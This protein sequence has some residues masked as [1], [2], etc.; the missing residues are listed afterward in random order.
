MESLEINLKEGEALFA[1]GMISEA[2]QLFLA[3]IDQSLSCKEAYNNL[4]VIAFQQNDKKS[5]I[6]YFTKALKADPFYK[7]AIMNYADLLRSMN[8]LSIAKPI[9]EKVAEKYP[10]DEEITDLINNIHNSINIKP[11]IAVICAS[12]WTGFMNEIVAF[13]ETRYEVVKCYTYSKKDI[14]AAISWSDIVWLEWASE[15]TEQISNSFSDILED[16]H[17]ICRLHSY[18]ALDGFVC[19]INWNVINDI[20]FV[21]KHIKDIAVEHEPELVDNVNNI[22]IVPNGTD[23]DRFTFKER[24]RGKNLAFIGNINFKKGPMLLLHAF[25]EL[26]QMDSEYRLFIAGTFQDTRYQHYFSQMMQELDLE[27][28]I[29]FDGWIKDINSWL[30]DKHY[31]VCASVLEGHPVGLMEAMARGLKPLIHNFVGARDIYPDKYVW[32][33]IPEFV[34]MAIENNYDPAEYRKFIEINYNL[35]KQL[36]SIDKIIQRTCKVSI[37]DSRS[38]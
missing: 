20:I 2:K 8:Q 31:I 28:N 6:E 13:L 25:R 4:G 33:T 5:S 24:T 27:S 26:V 7:E 12:D 18:E 34:R 15:L 9:V 32:N 19:K 29:E 1:D 16:K 22:C 37:A 11:K 38:A 35:E 21:A 14:L 36:D 30:E 17:V 23:M 10:D 3:L